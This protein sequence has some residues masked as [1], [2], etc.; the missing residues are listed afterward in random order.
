MMIL[1]VYDECTVRDLVFAF[2][3][4]LQAVPNLAGEQGPQILGATEL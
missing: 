3:S 4:H 2:V 1:F